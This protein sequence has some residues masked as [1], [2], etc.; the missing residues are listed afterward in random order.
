MLNE[1]VIEDEHIAIHDLR[2]ENEKPIGTRVVIRLV[3]KIKAQ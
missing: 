1:N 2:D 3:P